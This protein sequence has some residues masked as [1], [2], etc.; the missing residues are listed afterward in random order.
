MQLVFL[1]RTVIEGVLQ[2][3]P[4]LTERTWKNVK[5]FL[6]NSMRKKQLL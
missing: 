4:V 6:R 3:E 1:G 2:K 5:D